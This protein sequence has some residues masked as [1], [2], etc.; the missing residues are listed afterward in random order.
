MGKI[1]KVVTIL[2]SDERTESGNT[3]STPVEAGIF[4]E[5]NLVLDITAVAGTNPTLDISIVTYDKTSKKWVTVDSFEQKTGTGTTLKTITANL[6]YKIAVV[7]TIGGTETPSFT[8]SLG[9]VIK[10]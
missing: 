2:E 7:W 3:E 5:T 6:G 1:Y 8:F 9:A 10:G 4:Q